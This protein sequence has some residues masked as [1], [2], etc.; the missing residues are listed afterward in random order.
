ML[1]DL[2]GFSFAGAAEKNRE[3]RISNRF[4]VLSRIP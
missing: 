4:R 1:N 3:R 2:G